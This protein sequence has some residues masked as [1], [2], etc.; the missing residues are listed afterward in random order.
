[1]TVDA[2]HAGKAAFHAHLA[3]HECCRSRG[4][5]CPTCREALRGRRG[6]VVVAWRTLRDI[7]LKFCAVAV[8]VD[9]IDPVPFPWIRLATCAAFAAS[10][11]SL[12]AWRLG[13]RW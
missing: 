1:M 4:T 11:A 6:A 9:Y 5:I 12:L 2:L 10:F 8:M 7:A 13:R 3:E